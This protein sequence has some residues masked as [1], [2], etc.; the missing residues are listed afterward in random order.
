MSKSTL[1]KARSLFPFIS[2]RNCP[3]FA[4]FSPSTCVITSSEHKQIL[5][6][7]SQHENFYFWLLTLFLHLFIHSLY[8]SQPPRPD[9]KK[10]LQLVSNFHIW[11]KISKYREYHNKCQQYNLQS[12][13]NDPKY[14]K[15]SQRQ[16][17][18]ML[19]YLTL[20]STRFCRKFMQFLVWIFQAWKM[21]CF[22]VKTN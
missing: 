19:L 14:K 4:D 3:V 16:N 15:T 18:Q 2:R 20:S 5:P 12:Q 6:E 8:L 7:K 17:N 21:R 22:F 9:D 11:T 1:N 13:I 10:I